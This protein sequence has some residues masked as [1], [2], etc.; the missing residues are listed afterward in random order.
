MAET[1]GRDGWLMRAIAGTDTL[2]MVVV[3]PDEQEA[4]R[5][6]LSST[7]AASPPL[8]NW[9]ITAATP[10]TV[11]AGGTEAT[12]HEAEP[13][14]ARL[15]ELLPDGVVVYQ[16][17]VVRMVNPAG[18][19]MLGYD[20]PDELVGQPF[21]SIVHPDDHTLVRERVQAQL[22]HGEMVPPVVERFLDRHGRV[23]P[24]EVAAGP[25]SLGGRPA[26][27]VVVRD[28]TARQRLEARAGQA[29]RMEALGRL[30]G[31][32]AHDFNNFLTAIVGY[33]DLVRQ[34][35]PPDAPALA[36]ASALLHTTSR[37]CDLTRQLLTFSRHKALTLEVL[38]LGSL[39]IKA[40]GILTRLIGEDIAVVL[41]TDPEA[42]CVL[43]DSAQI[44]QVLMNL[45][46]NAREAMPAGGRLTLSISRY[47]TAD[48]VDSQPPLPP[49][50]YV[51]LAI[52][53]TGT[54]MSAE[55]QAR[56]FEPFFTT[57]EGGTGLGLF[58]VYGI[59]QQS[60][61]A[62]QVEST[63][64]QG[65][66]F[67]IFLPRTEDMPTQTASPG[68]E[69]CVPGTETLLI[70]ED[71]DLV[72]DLAVRVLRA[73][74]YTVA[75][76][77]SGMEALQVS[78]RLPGPLHLVLTDVVLPDTPGPV[79]LAG[80]R[81]H[82]PQMKVLYMSGYDQADSNHASPAG[83]PFIAK[84]FTPAALTR[85]IRALLDEER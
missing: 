55:V 5:V 74:G 80:L 77:A 48:A 70:V 39:V 7:A 24:V 61:G 62:I 81:E 57:K 16:D 19:H 69:G 60:G 63:E 36:D 26:A 53:D 66:T 21:L 50:E 58:T 8:R 32:I 9:E 79:L 33:A 78:L 29:Q 38:D 15:V 85:R 68:S 23:I 10:V 17:G 45:A 73:S 83:Q 46:I 31:G 40:L 37:A 35:L 42:G 3:T 64:G 12:A 34:T 25:F 27:L 67:R 71:N 76:A 41:E 13:R 43:A 6:F 2:E 84:P 30:A 65:T 1:V 59:V 56:L 75:E 49:G 28:V 20:A 11:L 72:R 4:R 44:E 51:V 18:A 22:E 47:T 14:Y 54:G 82:H 52:S